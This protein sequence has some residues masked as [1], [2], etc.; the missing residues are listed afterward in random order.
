[1][2]I[3]KENERKNV[4]LYERK[5]ACAQEVDLK[6]GLKTQSTHRQKGKYK[7]RECSKTTTLC[8]VECILHCNVLPVIKLFSM[9]II[10]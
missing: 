8:R 6:P 9:F 4:E 1:M 3:N 2:H 7:E 5:C 10:C